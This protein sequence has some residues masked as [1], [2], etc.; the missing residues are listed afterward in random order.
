MNKKSYT[1]IAFAIFLIPVFLLSCLSNNKQNNYKHSWINHSEEL[2]ILEEEFDENKFLIKEYFDEYFTIAQ[3]NINVEI[4]N[5]LYK[6]KYIEMLKDIQIIEITQEEANNISYN[7]FTGINKRYFAVRALYPL[8]GGR[9]IIDLTENNNLYIYYSVMSRGVYKP[10]E[11]AL[12]IEIDEKPNN[13]YIR[14][15]MVR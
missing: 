11:D 3:Y 13:I 7:I 12:I 9:Y 6:E 1:Y 14:Y 10:N 8:K 15:V 2:E 4:I 5:S